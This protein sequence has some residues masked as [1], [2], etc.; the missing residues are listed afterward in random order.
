MVSKL[1]GDAEIEAKERASSRRRFLISKR[2][3]DE[4]R[5]SAPSIGVDTF[6]MM[7]EQGKCLSKP[8]STNVEWEPNVLIEEPFAARKFPLGKGDRFRD[9]ENGRTET[10]APL[11]S[12]KSFFEILS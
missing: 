5:K 3:P 10:S 7:K 12:R 4:R 11:S 1:V 8:R 9:R 2:R 6:A